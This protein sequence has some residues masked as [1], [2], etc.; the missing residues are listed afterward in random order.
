MAR[1]VV[2]YRDSILAPA[3]E[4]FALATASYAEGEIESLELLDSQ[5]TLQTVRQELAGSVFD[6][7]LA[8]IDLEQ[9][10]GADLGWEM[11]QQP[12]S[13]HSPGEDK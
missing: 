9:A 1:Q 12:I 11:P 8:L 3:E 10:V 4:A 6:H 7:N 2:R 5:R 13:T